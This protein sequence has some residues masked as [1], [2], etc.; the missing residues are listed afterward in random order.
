MGSSARVSAVTQEPDKKV[1][2]MGLSNLWDQSVVDKAMLAAEKYTPDILALSSAE[3]NELAGDK[4]QYPDLFGGSWQQNVRTIFEHKASLRKILILPSDKSLG[5]F[6]DFKRYI[7]LLFGNDLELELVSLRKDRKTPF[8]L[9]QGSEACRDYNNYNYV[10]EGLKRALLQ[11]G[12]GEGLAPD[13]ISIDATAGTAI[14][15]IAAA[16]ITLN[17]KIKFVYVTTDGH[18]RN[19]DARIE[20]LGTSAL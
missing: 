13:E 14:F 20:L 17:R 4:A 19:Y 9:Y 10:Y 11:A 15:S 12:L 8:A 16:V 3:F 18:V 5:Q 6:E 1:L 7:G 2:I